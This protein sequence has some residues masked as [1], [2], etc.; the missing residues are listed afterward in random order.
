MATPTNRQ[1]REFI[2]ASFN[3]NELYT[4]CFDYF[5]GVE[6]N[7]SDSMP[8]LKK[9]IELISYCNRHQIREN[10]L[11][12]L[13]QERGQTYRKAF[14]SQ[15]QKSTPPLRVYEPR[16]RNPKQI[17]VSH[18]SKDATLAYQIAHDLKTAS[19]S[20]FITPESIRPGEKWAPAIDRG[21]DE[22]G[23]FLVL[24]TPNAMKSNWVIDETYIAIEAANRNE[25]RVLLL[26]VQPC[27]VPGTW[28]QR[29]F[30]SFREEAYAQSLVGLLTAITGA[31][32][33]APKLSKQPPS[34]IKVT[35]P[36]P[37]PLQQPEPIHNSFVHE[38]T[39]LEFVRI[40]AGEFLYGNDKKSIKLPEYWISKTPVTQTVYQRFIA[41]NSKQ[42]V[43]KDWNQQKRTF[44]DGKAAHPVIY[45]NWYDA[46]AFCEWAGLALPTEEQW[47]KAA[48][49]TD[50]RTY[51]WGN[52]EPTDNL[53][54]F[55]RNVGRTT[56]EGQYSPQGDSPY[57]CV[58]MS[59]NVWEWCLNK[60]K[61]PEVT[62]IDQSEA[63]RVLRG[64]AWSNPRNFVRAAY[65]LSSH[66]ANRFDLYGFR[67]VAVRPPSQ[68]L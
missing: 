43:P 21:L 36:Q 12:A 44:P 47:E 38:K 29:Q 33:P 61:T 8:M 39:G 10:L 4:F 48:R 6:H 26:D 16:P 52:N 42:D 51:P 34:P 20:I 35:T 32:A 59:G 45:V 50:G 5:E 62:E 9:V 22:S 63:W 49:G 53:C 17:F 46:I 55:D 7:F 58:D 27:S 23:L 66:P 60:Y 67:V 1:L 11:V 30:V 37:K 40:S 31:K 24:L 25:M 2:L 54:N 13:E 57:G 65:R 3:E 18:S 14:A 28:R 64:G 68:G 15:Q 56:P 41:A 19:Y